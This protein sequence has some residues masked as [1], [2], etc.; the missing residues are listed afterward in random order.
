CYWT[1][2]ASRR[3]LTGAGV[4]AREQAL[5][6][7]ADPLIT[8][9]AR[10]FETGA[11]ADRQVAPAVVE[12]TLVGEPADRRRHGAACRCAWR[13]STRACRLRPPPGPA[14]RPPRPASSARSTR[15]TGRGRGP[16]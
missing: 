8:G 4:L 2:A 9:A 1:T 15:G 13:R 5:V 12:H 14:A 16:R 10:R 11:V 3:R 6:V 7:G